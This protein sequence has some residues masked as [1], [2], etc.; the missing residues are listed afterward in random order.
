MRATIIVNGRV[1]GVGYRRFVKDKAATF[2]IKGSVRNLGSG[3]VEIFVEGDNSEIG[4]FVEFLR[5]EKPSAW[6][7]EVVEVFDEKH[8]GYK[9]PW[10]EV[11]EG[12]LVDWHSGD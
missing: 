5:K 11:S 1:Q 12:F 4:R 10:R 7:I 2:H 9:G 6:N 8:A 3:S